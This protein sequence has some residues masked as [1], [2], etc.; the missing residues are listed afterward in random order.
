MPMVQACACVKYTIT[1]LKRDSIHTYIITYT[2]KH[3]RDICTISL[4][5]LLLCSNYYHAHNNGNLWHLTYIHM[6]MCTNIFDLLLFESCLCFLLPLLRG[7]QQRLHLINNLINSYRGDTCTSIHKHEDDTIISYMHATIPIHR[8][9]IEQ[10]APHTQ[11][12]VVSFEAEI[13]HKIASYQ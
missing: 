11:H 6:Y 10:Q 4:A 9:V 13:F 1:F 3:N 8:K 7:T 12:V 5:P 2:V